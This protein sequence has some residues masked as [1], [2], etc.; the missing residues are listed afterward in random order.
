MPASARD[1]GRWRARSCAGERP[2][3]ARTCTRSDACCISTWPAVSRMVA[4]FDLDR[5]K[6]LGSLSGCICSST[7]RARGR[8]PRSTCGARS[9]R[10]CPAD[11]PALVR[12]SWPSPSSGAARRSGVGAIQAAY[13]ST[14]DKM[15]D[16]TQEIALEDMEAADPKDAPTAGDRA[17]GRR[18]RDEVRRSATEA[19]SK[20][21]A[22]QRTRAWRRRR[23]LHNPSTAV[24]EEFLATSAA[25]RVVAAAGTASSWGVARSGGTC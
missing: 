4:D 9:S 12:G 25:A 21:A 22:S 16:K 17:G 20:T 11:A 13:G 3:F 19:C 10:F 5:P 8:F 24:H 14:A 2:A 6:P 15:S 23:Q 1:A 7:I 18:S